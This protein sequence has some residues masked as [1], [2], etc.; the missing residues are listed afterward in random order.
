[1][2]AGSVAEAVVVDGAPP[3]VPGVLAVV[4]L[5][6]LTAWREPLGRLTLA[7]AVAVLKMRLAGLL[8]VP[9]ALF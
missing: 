4:A 1:V 2:F 6:V 3:G 9:V 8:A 5:V 7:V